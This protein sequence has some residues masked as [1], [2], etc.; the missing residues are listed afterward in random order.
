M[1]ILLVDTTE[2]FPASPLFHEALLEVAAERGYDH[3]FA[4]E[5]AYRYRVEG[6]LA[7]KLFYRAT[8]RRPLSYRRFN[9]ALLRRAEMFRPDVVLVVKGASI[10]PETLR[11]IKGLGRPFLINFT[12]DDP[13]NPASS[14]GPLL[15]SLPL[16]DLICSPRRAPIPEI[17]AL[18]QAR[19][20]YVR[21]GY[22]PS[23]HF[24][25]SVPTTLQDR[26]ACDV[27]FIGGSDADRAR[28]LR[29][30]ATEMSDVRL[31]LYG[32]AW[33]RD[34]LLHR[35]ARGFVYGREYR[36]AVG[37]AKIVLN[38]VRRANRDG[39]VMRTFEVPACGGFMLSD[40]TDEHQELFSEAVDAVFFEGLEELVTQ[41][42]RYLAATN[43]RVA[44]S[45]RAHRSVV[46][47]ANSYADRLRQIIGFVSGD[48]A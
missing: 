2:Y 39:H 34:P 13:F 21:F 11:S 27:A 12:T 16:Y 19:V 40:R 18:T 10:S 9:R 30:I 5:N 29:A 44:I 31:F 23:V 42:K 38:L 35:Y 7:H 32:N 22:K 4:D 15:R 33:D 28:Y 25:E 17:R 20:E 1:R 37:A 41:V 47:G 8:G 14:T 3:E 43:D 45:G 6:T 48:V 26:Y 46:D 24:P 36:Y